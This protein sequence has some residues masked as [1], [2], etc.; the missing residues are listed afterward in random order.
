MAKLNVNGKSHD[1][2]ADPGTP[3]LWVLREQLGM[4]GTKYGCGVAQCGACTVL[5]D[6]VPTRSCIVPAASVKATAKITTSDATM[7]GTTGRARIA[8]PVAIAADTPQIEMPDASG[9]AHSR[10]NPNHFRAM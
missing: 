1:Y 2:Q 6:G 8:L 9:A 5:I 3:L 10:L 7:I 4:T